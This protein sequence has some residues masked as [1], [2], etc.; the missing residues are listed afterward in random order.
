MTGGDI[1]APLEA[2]QGNCPACPLLGEKPHQ[3]QSSRGPRPSE[4]VSTGGK[5]RA[6]LSMEAE[7]GGGEV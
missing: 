4:S 5:Q 1:P 2:P 6:G 7:G 3:T